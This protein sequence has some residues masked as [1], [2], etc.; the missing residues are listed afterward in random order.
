[1]N[2]LNG[3]IS[4]DAETINHAIRICYKDKNQIKNDVS[5]EIINLLIKKG[6]LRYTQICRE[7]KKTP[8]STYINK[9]LHQL[10]EL[11]FLTKRAPE[12]PPEWKNWI[13]STQKQFLIDTYGIR[14]LKKLERARLYHYEPSKI[15]KLLNQARFKITEHID[16]LTPI[17][18]Y[19]FQTLTQEAEA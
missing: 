16:K 18:T 1:M 12:L 19:P 15:V 4:V 2:S 10:I 3:S 9:K 8:R 17:E 13:Y 5:I 14:T 11:G 6:P 7:I